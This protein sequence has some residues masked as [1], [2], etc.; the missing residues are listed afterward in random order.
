MQVGTVIFS[1]FIIFFGECE[2]TARPALS[3]WSPVGRGEQTA[4]VLDFHWLDE[5]STARWL[6]AGKDGG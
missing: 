6:A 3:D 4:N 5:R 2:S 1:P